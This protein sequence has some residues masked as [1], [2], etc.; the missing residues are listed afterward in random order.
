MKWYHQVL[1]A[2]Y[3][4][5]FIFFLYEAIL[6]MFVYFANKSMG[7]Y[8]SFLVPGRNLILALLFGCFAFFGW[9]L[10]KTAA[11]SKVGALLLY[12]PIICILLFMLWFIILLIS[13]GGKW[14]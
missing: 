1:I 10:L 12:F 8:E 6:G 14:N 3:S 2:L 13:S 9:K 7:H 4:M 11:M 5:A